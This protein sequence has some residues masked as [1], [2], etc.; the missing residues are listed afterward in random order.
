MYDALAGSNGQFVDLVNSK[1]KEVEM[2][3]EDQRLNSQLLSEARQASERFKNRRGR[4]RS[5]ESSFSSNGMK[6]YHFLPD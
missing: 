4:R 1:L 6:K 3:A 2:S 5:S